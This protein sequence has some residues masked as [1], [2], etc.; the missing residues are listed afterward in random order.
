MHGGPGGVQDPMAGREYLVVVGESG[1]E[2]EAGEHCVIQ[3]LGGDIVGGWEA[4]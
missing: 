2:F 4:R 1:A 3:G